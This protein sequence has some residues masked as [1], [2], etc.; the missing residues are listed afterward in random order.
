MCLQRIHGQSQYRKRV[1]GVVHPVG[2]KPQTVYWRR[3]AV[4][5]VVV[6]L[7]LYLLGRAIFGGNSSTGTPVAAPS[8]SV[9]QSA[10]ASS[11][12]TT[13][14]T[15]SV[16]ATPEDIVDPITQQSASPVST[17]V[18][19]P[20]TCGDSEV[21]VKVSIKKKVVKVGAGLDINMSVKNISKHACKRDVGSG[22]NEVTIISGPALVWSTDHC[23]TGTES[24]YVDLVPG[25]TWS[26]HVLWNGKLSAPNCQVLANAQYGAY[27]AH[28][29]NGA[30]VSSGARFVIQ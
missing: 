13:S 10:S 18:A 4:F 28:A 14:A 22:A 3:R 6:L 12:P 5:A 20:G 27:W 17:K 11:K 23:G 9:V 8:K 2:P 1:S 7:T 19:P 26:V 25:E 30:V 15:P 29:R 21:S 16:S 24:N